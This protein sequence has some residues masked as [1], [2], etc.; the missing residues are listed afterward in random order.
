MLSVKD[1]KHSEFNVYPNPNNGQFTIDLLGKTTQDYNAILTNALG[2]I[3]HEVQLKPTSKLDLHN[4]PTG[5][6]VLTIV[7]PD[8]VESI[9]LIIR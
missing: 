6:Y 7:G 3:V 9:Q 4:L 1:Y 8:S 5:M 2:E